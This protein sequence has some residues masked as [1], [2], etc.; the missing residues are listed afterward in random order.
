MSAA[1]ESESTREDRGDRL[2]ALARTLA[3]LRG[4]AIAGQIGAVVYVAG[5]LA[6]PLPVAALLGC[7]AGLALFA[8]V[9]AWRL[10]R[11]PPIGESEIVAHLFIDIAA[12]AGV[13][14]LTGGASNPFVSLLIVP[15]AL[16]ATALS[17]RHV[18]AVIM[19]ACAA[20]LALLIAYRPL[21]ALFAHDAHAEF[22]AHVFGMAVNFAISALL[23]G[24]FITRLARELRQRD[25]AA[26]RER[27]RA[28][29]DE[30][31]LAIATQ[32]AGTAHELNTP[33]STM[34]TLLTELRRAD[35]PQLREDLATLTSQVERCR[36]ILRDLVA[37]GT[38]QLRETPQELTLS[39]FVARCAERFRLLRPAVDLR[40][41]I[42][43]RSGA[44]PVHVVPGVQH[45]L[46]NL[47]SN[48]ADAS[49][50]RDSASIELHARCEGIHVDF[51]V[52]DHGPG[53]P[54][55]ARDAIGRRFFSDK[56]SGLGIGFALANATADR[57]HGTLSVSPVPE[58]GTFTRL[59]LPLGAAHA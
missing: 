35:P 29:R 4:V 59:R 58:G 54:A 13:L 8:G 50:A 33:L 1:F 19:I 53:L 21:P 42:D 47:L 45:S 23:L 28:L 39:D 25:A 9:I 18:A 12:L 14:A 52:R 37:V 32:A 10:R 20:Y 40:I 27:E 6:M 24:F 22:G 11:A 44:R 48:A 49:A 34:L 7:A 55:A 41:D 15:V 26:R 38:A 36:D 56:Q 46:L 5:V 3:R 30:G 57:L 17:A 2:R 31:I 51:G 16:A 43:D